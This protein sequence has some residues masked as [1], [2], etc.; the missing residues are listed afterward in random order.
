VKP[1]AWAGGALGAVGLVLAVLWT[2]FPQKTPDEA[3]LG[4]QP[5]AQVTPSTTP[6]ASN[7]S[8]DHEVTAWKAAEETPSG[9]AYQAYLD[10]YPDGMFAEL[11]R[12]RLSDLEATAWRSAEQLNSRY[13][14]QRFLSEYPNSALVALANS[15]MKQLR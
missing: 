6:E 8:G 7:A 12:S 5:T 11:A 10:R 9:A 2:A 13:A 4:E 15:R 14:Y 3:K 1:F